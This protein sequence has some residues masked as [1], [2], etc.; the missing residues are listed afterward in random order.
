MCEKKRG[1]IQVFKGALSD[2]YGNTKK[3][4]YE[5]QRR[6]YKNIIL[7]RQQQLQQKQQQNFVYPI[8]QF[9]VIS[10]FFLKKLKAPS[11]LPRNGSELVKYS[12]N[13]MFIHSSSVVRSSIQ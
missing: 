1:N 11:Q 4:Y 13:E 2:G 9:T 10:Y 3:K 5:I 12:L 6:K 7:L 8:W